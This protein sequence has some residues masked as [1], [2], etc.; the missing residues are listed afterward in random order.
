M[1]KAAV[2]RALK[3]PLTVEDVSPPDLAEGQVR[4]R[5]AASGICHSQLLEVRGARGEDRFLPHLLGHEASGVVEEIGRGVTRVRPGDHAVLSWIKGP[6]LSVGGAKYRD[7][8]GDVVN[9]G[10]VATFA[11]SAIVSE[12]RVTP[13]RRDLPLDLAA[14]L[15]CAVATGAGAILN[16]AGVRPGDRV[17]VFGAG[18]IGLNAIQ[19]A[20]IAGAAMIIAVDIHDHKLAQAR[21]F[22]ATQTVN[23]RQ[24]E[25]S[26]AI[27]ELTGGKGV[28]CA[29][30]SAGQRVSME[31]AFASVR[32]GGGK[33]IL[34]GNLPAG[35]S[36]SIDP[37]QL[38]CGREILGCW[39]GST[40]PERDFPR[41]ADLFMEGKLK[42]R[43]LVSH[44]FRLDEVN[45]AL[46]ALE[47]G[48]VARGLIVF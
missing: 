21:E 29:I 11:E 5:I 37:F 26:A 3:A 43:E 12:D 13:V 18:G 22:G 15:G 8:R 36:I 17:A 20:A 42:L 6:G 9:S 25:A 27:R 38:I 47:R 46:A 32:T 10:A 35:Q 16:T 30:E 44:R 41:Y 28:D 48:D 39:G 19:A 45:E 14:L 23:G 4:V 31:Q 1:I 40:R 7:S 2:L 34:V 33:A 24:Q